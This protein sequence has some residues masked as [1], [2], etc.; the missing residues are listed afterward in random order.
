M[1]RRLIANVRIRLACLL[2]DSAP[3]Y[4]PDKPDTWPS[5]NPEGDRL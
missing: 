3:P 5:L 2:A 1:I 4:D